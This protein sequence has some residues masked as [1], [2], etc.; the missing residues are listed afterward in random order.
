MKIN[1]FLEMNVFLSSYI[2]CL[3]R[4]SLYSHFNYFHS[5]SS[6]DLALNHTLKSRMRGV[7]RVK[8]QSPAIPPFKHSPNLHGR[9]LLEMRTIV[10]K[11]E[12][13]FSSLPTYLDFIRNNYSGLILR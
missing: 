12:K 2:S 9:L 11:Y 7:I 1:Y 4:L 10:C 8:W 3:H 6:R 5:R 13:G